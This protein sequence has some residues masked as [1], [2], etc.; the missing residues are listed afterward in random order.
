MQIGIVSA[1][2]SIF[3]SGAAMVITNQWRGTLYVALSG[4]L[5]G[6]IGYFGTT[7]LMVHFSVSCML[8]W[9]FLMA[10]CWMLVLVA[11]KRSL[12]IQRNQLPVI[13]KILT[14]GAITYSGSSA[15]YFLAS[16]QIGTGMAMV[17]FF[18]FPIF[19]MA[20][21]WFFDKWQLNRYAVLS[22]LLVIVGLFCLRGQG[23][24][25]L[26]QYGIG[27]SLVAGFFYAVYIYTSREYTLSLSPESVAF[28]VCLGNMFIFLL[29]TL[30]T[31][32]FQFPP[33]VGSWLYIGA[34]GII[35]T[36]LPIQLLLMGL[37]Y[38]S[39]VKT[40]ILSVL[41]PVV[42]V[43]VG[44]ILLHEP[45]NY[46]QLVGIMSVLAGAVFIQFEKNKT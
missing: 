14:L 2:L 18:S 23:D 28:W 12:L 42:T 17:I 24:H 27:L 7:L 25:A 32:Q 43:I 22:L 6:G 3:R 46:I 9:R 13:F 36:A 31:R 41:E 39:P 11:L 35:A 45:L 16:Q 1:Q 40:S 4:I 37:Q 10:S 29:I 34:I 20:F 33:T 44:Y 15:Y 30:F 26:N 38:I 8:F 5:Y 19:V 21:S